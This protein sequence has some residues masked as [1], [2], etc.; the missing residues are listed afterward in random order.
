MTRPRRL[1][2][3]LAAVLAGGGIAAFVRHGAATRGSATGLVDERGAD[4]S[5][6]AQA[7]QRRAQAPWTPPP[8]RLQAPGTPQAA[9]ASPPVQND[10]RAP[11]YDPVR[12]V[13]IGAPL[14]EILAAEPRLEAWAKPREAFLQ[15]QVTGDLASLV[16]EG[17]L[18]S[19][20]CRTSTCTLTALV[21]AEKLNAGMFAL[22]L[23]QL[24][25]LISTGSRMLPDGMAAVEL[26][27]LF[28]PGSRPER[29][30]QRDYQA[31]RQRRLSFLRGT[32]AI[33]QRT[34]LG[35][36]ALPAR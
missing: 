3:V 34:G 23:S 2:L 19:V 14:Q 28:S 15:R 6:G 27:A 17:K 7:P 16:P 21:P 9:A 13:Q 12:L 33:Y 36:A 26:H 5:P 31:D 1:V 32:P 4:Q 8:P 20:T 29:D 11:D 24:G 30:Y 18:E 10:P 22:Q 35:P 25:D